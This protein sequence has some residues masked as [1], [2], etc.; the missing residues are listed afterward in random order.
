EREHAQADE[1]VGDIGRAAAHPRAH[2][3]AGPGGGLLP[4]D[5]PLAVHA[6]NPHG[7]GALAVRAGGALA[8]LAAHV[9]H[10][11]GMAGA[12][13]RPLRIRGVLGAVAVAGSFHGLIPSRVPGP[14]PGA[15]RP[16]VL[17]RWCR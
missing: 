4:G 5:L 13:R 1:R 14:L 12:H 8:A 3:V 17:T 7:G 15:A 10:P 9:A 11:I 2:R 6:E 16:A